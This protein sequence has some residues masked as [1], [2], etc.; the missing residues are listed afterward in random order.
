MPALDIMLAL[1]HA[2]HHD[3]GADG[4]LHALAEPDHL[5]AAAAIVAS[6]MVARAAYRRIQ[7]HGTRVGRRRKTVRG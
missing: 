4:L 3:G 5:L 1:A 2:G 6:L 7:S